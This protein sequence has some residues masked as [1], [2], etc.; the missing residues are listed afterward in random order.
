MYSSIV[1]C[2][3]LRM[4]IN[5]LSRLYH[6]HPKGSCYHITRMR[7]IQCLASIIYACARF[8]QTHNNRVWIILDTA[9]A[10][11]GKGP[12]TRRRVAPPV[13]QVMGWVESKKTTRGV[14][15][16]QIALKSSPVPS[17]RGSPSKK[18][19]PNTPH[20]FHSS[21][22]PVIDIEALVL[23][24]RGVSRADHDAHIL[25]MI[26]MY[27]LKMTI[28]ASGFPEEISTWTEY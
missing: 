16:R 8:K 3:M 1:P 17:P 12:R 14:R 21:A 22:E 25:L 19:R 26:C 10:S 11:M 27:R 6:A 23:P 7:A 15:I 2:T 4:E 18:S 20:Q 28:Y 24:H 5:V 13:V 9:I